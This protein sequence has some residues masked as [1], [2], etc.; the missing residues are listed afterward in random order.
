MIK[1][2]YDIFG[3]KYVA[4]VST[5]PD[6][7]LG[8]ESLWREAEA[9]LKNA[10]KENGME[11]GLKDKDGAFYGP[12]IDFQVKD[13]MGREWQ[14]ATVQL[15]YQLPKRLR[16]HLHRRGREGA[17]AC[18]DT[19]GHIRI[20]REIPG[21]PGG[22]CAGQ[23]PHMACAGAGAG[24]LDIRPDAEVRRG[25]LRQDK[26]EKVR[27]NLDNSDRTLQYKIREAQLQQVPYVIVLRERRSRRA[28]LS[29]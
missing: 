6:S 11:F 16:P 3:L 2:L 4:K 29:P 26:A 19:Q 9:S 17:R 27:A 18:D 14:C 22:A 5:M 28:A 8:D 10:L 15:D 25:G 21:R 13:S 12:K 7:H 20:P 1:E 24:R 23:V